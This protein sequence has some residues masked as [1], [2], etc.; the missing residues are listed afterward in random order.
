MQFK[1]KQNWTVELG[2]RAGVPF[3]RLVAE[4]RVRVWGGEC[5]KRVKS[6]EFLSIFCFSHYNKCMSKGLGLGGA[7]VSELEFYI[8]IASE[9]EYFFIYVSATL[10]RHVC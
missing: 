10:F 7:V 9:V 3:G 4:E 2:V 1:N 8:V 5:I 6:R